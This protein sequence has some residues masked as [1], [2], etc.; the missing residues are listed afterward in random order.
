M[1]DW[2]ARTVLFPLPPLTRSPRPRS[3]GHV[4]VRGLGAVIEFEQHRLV[5][6]RVGRHVDLDPAHATG[7]VGRDEHEVPRERRSG[8]LDLVVHTHRGRMRSPWM[9]KLPRI[10]IGRR[11]GVDQLHQP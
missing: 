9:G 7:D 5:I 3:S 6:R 2:S 8:P 11:C 4:R 10:A 1:L